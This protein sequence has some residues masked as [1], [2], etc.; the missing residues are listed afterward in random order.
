MPPRRSTSTTFPRGT[1]TD[2]SAARRPIST[3]PPKPVARPPMRS[4]SL[5]GVVVKSID[6]AAVRRAVDAYAAELLQRPEVEEVV[7]FGSFETDTYAPG[8]DLDVLI[9]LRV[10]ALPIHDR[11]AHYRGGALPV[12]LDLFP[13]TRS[14]ERQPLAVPPRCK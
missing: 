14:G 7:V 11:A 13:F 5:S 10:S 1:R 6:K 9:V 4:G 8:S 12:P 2:S 3:R